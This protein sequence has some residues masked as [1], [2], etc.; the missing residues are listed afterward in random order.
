M[1]CIVPLV[2]VTYDDSISDA[3][4]RK[5]GELLP[6]LVS[7]VVDCPEEPWVPP[8]GT[9]DLDI[10]FHARSSRDVGELN[11]VIEVRTKFFASRERDKQA[12][13]DL[14]RDGIT[15]AV[16]LGSFGVWLILA[17]GAWAQSSGW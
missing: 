5:L 4:L 3:A 7:E 8:L 10:R 15:S 1:V 6:H 11:C 14:L 12:R 2:D 16:E 9:G 13:V 17:E